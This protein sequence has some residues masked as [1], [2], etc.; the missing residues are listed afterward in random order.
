MVQEM[1]GLFSFNASPQSLHYHTVPIVPQSKPCVLHPNENFSFEVDHYSL[2]IMI[3]CYAANP[4]KDTVFFEAGPTINWTNDSV[5]F[6]RT[7][8]VGGTANIGVRLPISLKSKMFAIEAMGGYS[9]VPN[10]KVINGSGFHILLGVG[11]LYGGEV[12][13][14]VKNY[15]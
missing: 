5:Y 4:D 12:R 13:G 3:R 7:T 15:F 9:Y 11:Y 1:W 6:V 8:T 2:P 10:Q 14:R